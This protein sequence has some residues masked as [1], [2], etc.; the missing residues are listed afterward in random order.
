MGYVYY[1]R[2]DDPDDLDPPPPPELPREEPPLDIED[3][4]LLLGELCDTPLF[5]LGG[6]EFLC[7]AA[8][9]RLVEGGAVDV[10]VLPG[11]VVEVLVPVG[12]VDV[13]VR[14]D[15]PTVDL[16]PSVVFLEPATGRLPSVVLPVPIVFLLFVREVPVPTRLPVEDLTPSV[17][18]LEALLVPVTIRPFASRLTALLDLTLELLARVLNRSLETDLSDTR[19]DLPT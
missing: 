3:P 11:L 2:L 14:P 10:L 19:E 16:L 5:D 9:V 8:S 12:A 7:G 15:E 1:Y 17:L 6:G 13:L 18:R 4:L